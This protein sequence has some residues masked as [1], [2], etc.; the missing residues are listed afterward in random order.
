MSETETLPLEIQ[1]LR[2]RTKDP[3]EIVRGL[4][5]QVADAQHDAERAHEERDED[6]A[7]YEARIEDLVAKE[8]SLEVFSD[9][10]QEAHVRAHHL[11]PWEACP[12][13]VCRGLEEWMLRARKDAAG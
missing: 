1:W 13:L 3:E 11:G 9:A 12:N 10:I 8:T 5:R 4:L 2:L 6:A 7:D